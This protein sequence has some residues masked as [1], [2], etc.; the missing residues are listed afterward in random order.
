MLHWT[1]VLC[2]AAVPELYGPPAYCCCLLSTA[3]AA[4]RYSSLAKS[5]AIIYPV[6][7][8]HGHS[9]VSFG[10]RRITAKVDTGDND[11]CVERDSHPPSRDRL[12][13]GEPK[14]RS[15]QNSE[16][17]DSLETSTAPEAFDPFTV[18][19]FHGGPTG[20]ELKRRHARL[21]REQH[22]RRQWTWSYQRKLINKNPSQSER[23]RLRPPFGGPQNSNLARGVPSRE[24]LKSRFEKILEEEL[25]LHHKRKISSS[26]K[27]QKTL[28]FGN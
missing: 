26:G 17:H 28:T 11:D 14:D 2:S 13:K 4:R 1:R 7:G 25:D 12:I 20:Q 8:R 3:V 6:S 16:S 21:G 23:E 9:S 18:D 19:P 22:E 24:E 15:Q 27:A 10:K 5:K